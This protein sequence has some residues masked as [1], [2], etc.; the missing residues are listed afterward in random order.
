MS[1][2]LKLAVHFV[3][4]HLMMLGL[5]ALNGVLALVHMHLSAEADSADMMSTFIVSAAGLAYSSWAHRQNA[6]QHAA[7]G[8]ELGKMAANAT[9][10]ADVGATQSSPNPPTKTP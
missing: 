8:Y 5:P 9:A 3:V 7:A 1:A 6:Q 4:S 2:K 10:A